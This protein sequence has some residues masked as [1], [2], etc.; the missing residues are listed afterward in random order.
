MKISNKFIGHRVYLKHLD[1]EDATQKYCDWLND[2]Q[3]N[4]YLATKNATISD[5][6][7]YILNKNNQ[8]NTLLFGIF[9]I[10]DNNYIGTVK[11]EPID[12][13]KKEATIA[14]MIGDKNYWG[15]GLA[16]EA[17]KLLIDYCFN[18]LGYR[19]INLGVTKQNE[20][21]VRTYQKLGFSIINIEEKAVRYPNGI[22]D[23]VT[24]EIKN[25]K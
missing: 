4:K 21:A 5:L 9:M 7:S 6:Q 25:K 15:K 17:M 22:F 24:M 8:D 14:I 3:V 20:S 13:H 16:G 23:Q 1:K 18:N 12:F 10:E 11:L 2:S 19:S